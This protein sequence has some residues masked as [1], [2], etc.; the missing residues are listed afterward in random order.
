[1]RPQHVPIFIEDED[2][3]TSFTDPVDAA[4]P[5][6]DASCTLCSNYGRDSC[7][8]DWF[9]TLLH[10][11]KKPD[12]DCDRTDC[13]T[14]NLEWA[15]EIS[16]PKSIQ[17]ESRFDPSWPVL[18]KL[19]HQKE[20]KIKAMLA[21][22][23]SGE[24]TNKNIHSSFFEQAFM[25]KNQFV[26]ED[27][28]PE[29]ILRHF[30]RAHKTTPSAFVSSVDADKHDLQESH[31]IPISDPVTAFIQDT[32]DGFLASEA[33]DILSM[34]RGQ[35]SM[36]TALYKAA[37]AAIMRQLMKSW[38]SD[39]ESS[40]VN[41][42]EP[43]EHGTERDNPND[44]V[45]SVAS[46]CDGCA[47]GCES[48]YPMMK[49]N[50]CQ[51]AQSFNVQCHECDL[52][53]VFI[54]RDGNSECLACEWYKPVSRKNRKTLSAA[55]KTKDTDTN[56]GFDMPSSDLNSYTPQKRASAKSN[57]AFAATADSGA[58]PKVTQ[59]L[60]VTLS[61]PKYPVRQAFWAL[62][63]HNFETVNKTTLYHR[64]ML[65]LEFSD[66]PEHDEKM[67]KSFATILRHQKKIDSWYDSLVSNVV[68][69]QGFDPD[70]YVKKLI[71]PILVADGVIAPAFP[72]DLGDWWTKTQDEVLLSLKYANTMAPWTSFAK[73]LNKSASQCKERSKVIDST[74]SK[75]QTN[76]KQVKNSDKS[77]PQ[78]K[79][80]KAKISCKD[81]TSYARDAD[82]M[83]AYLGCSVGEDVFAGNEHVEGPQDCWG[84]CDSM[85]PFAGDACANVPAAN[86]DA[87]WANWTGAND[88][89]ALL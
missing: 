53:R 35:L 85:D 62:S 52:P 16:D 40:H 56:Q 88:S 9:D 38:R 64:L 68:E 77:A 71:G 14:C 60:M 20:A 29:R 22:N 84:G 13:L 65:C 80:T 26:P 30:H 69:L 1:M 66:R 7:K 2:S 51:T 55:K 82:S 25:R 24:A 61:I 3:P 21:E 83:N 50:R 46:P 57:S 79:K 75:T 67:M 23:V 39:N 33:A 76:G 12:C 87:P 72:Q 49:S 28:A 58:K 78:R 10:D 41:T 15:Q 45:D 43:V 47:F 17:P 42:S 86:V 54:D 34:C 4:A 36:A 63:L 8:P 19:A 18:K 37:G 73:T 27:L 5:S 11:E 6:E 59:C 74:K 89:D 32:R 48:C 31:R 44:D 70:V 81:A